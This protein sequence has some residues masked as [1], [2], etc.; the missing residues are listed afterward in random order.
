MP[1]KDEE[2]ILK[3]VGD[4][5]KNI[6]EGGVSVNPSIIMTA[7]GTQASKKP[8]AKKTK[9]KILVNNTKH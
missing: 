8:I 2:I 9:N 7:T 4:I 1:L 5:P 6:R 3:V